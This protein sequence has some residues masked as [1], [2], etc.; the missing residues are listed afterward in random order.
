MSYIFLPG[1]ALMFTEIVVPIFN[2]DSICTLPPMAL[3]SWLHE[4]NPIPTP[5]LLNIGF[6][7]V[8]I[9]P[10]NFRDYLIIFFVIPIPES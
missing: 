10:N 1:M 4:F 6:F 2:K 9:F 7:N 5:D 8:L 3:A